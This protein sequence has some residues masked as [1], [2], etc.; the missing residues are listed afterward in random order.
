M[1]ALGLLISNP[2]LLAIMAGI[3][4]AL[5]WGFV[6]RSTGARLEREKHGRER[7]A[8]IEDRLEMDRE[9]T[10]DERKAAG[11]TDAEAKAEALKWS[12]R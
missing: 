12:K 8:A 4:C 7:L 5:G 2:T 10:A 3:V 6:Q 11:M 9:A 1:G